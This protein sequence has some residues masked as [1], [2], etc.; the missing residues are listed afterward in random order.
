M[1]NPMKSIRGIWMLAFAVVLLALPGLAGA[2]ASAAVTGTLTYRDRVAL[3]TNAMATVQIARVYTDRSPEIIAEQTF[4]TN[5]AQPPFTYSIAYD[6]A[7][8]D[9]NASYTVQS[10][11]KVGDQVRYSTN[12]IVPVITRGNPTQNV[13]MTLVATGNLPNTSGGAW[14]LTLAGLALLAALGVFAVRRLRTA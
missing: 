4:T 5:G 3:P 10:T 9:Q 6:P 11:I 14:P 12:T 1:E 8:I 13:A 7:R 2:Q